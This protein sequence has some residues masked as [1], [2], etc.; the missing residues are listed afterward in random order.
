MSSTHFQLTSWPCSSS[1]VTATAMGFSEVSRVPG[2][3]V[4]VGLCD[5][6]VYGP[7]VA[8]E[9]LSSVSEASTCTYQ[10]PGFF[11]IYAPSSEEVNDEVE[12]QAALREANAK[13]HEAGSKRRGE[14]LAKQ[15]KQ[16]EDLG[17]KHPAHMCALVSEDPHRFGTTVS[18]ISDF[19][20]TH[21]ISVPV[22]PS[23]VIGKFIALDASTYGIYS[24]ANTPLT[25]K[26]KK[27]VALLDAM[28]ADGYDASDEEIEAYNAAAD[29]LGGN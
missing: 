25:D 6:T 21:G 26:C 13:R 11:V 1:T 15:V 27:Y 10:V 7:N 28:I 18:S 23:E 16:W 3:A 29:H 9:R 5:V 4:T 20:K 12:Q 19:V 22:G 17:A 14:W 8:Q 24:Y 2:M